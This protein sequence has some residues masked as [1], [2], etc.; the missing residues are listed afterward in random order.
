MYQYEDANFVYMV[1]DCFAGREIKYELQDIV[2]A[3]ES[4]VAELMYKLLLALSHC[5]SKNVIH[6]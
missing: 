4:V 2:K 6:G 3:P 5:H 1:F